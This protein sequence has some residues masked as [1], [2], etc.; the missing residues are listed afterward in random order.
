MTL[1]HLGDTVH[2][3]ASSFGEGLR[4]G[5]ASR[6]VSAYGDLRARSSHAQCSKEPRLRWMPTEG[7]V[8]PAPRRTP[9]G[10][11]ASRGAYWAWRRMIGDWG[12][13]RREWGLDV[14]EWEGLGATSFLAR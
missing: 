8:T 13:S 14:I 5:R 12:L 10:G 1:T 4:L 2:L 11:T 6:D 7:V 3:D 9:E